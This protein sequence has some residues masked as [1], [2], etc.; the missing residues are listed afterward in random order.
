MKRLSWKYIA[1]LLDGEG[2]FDFQIQV[3]SSSVKRRCPDIQ[4][5]KYPRPR[6]RVTLT[7][8]GKMVLE[9]L[10]ADHGGQF[11]VVNKATLKS[12][13]WTQPYTWTLSGKQLRPFLQNVVEHL[14]IKQQQAL[15]LIW[16][17]DNVKGKHASDVVRE[18]LIAELK[19]M[20]SDPQR[21]S[22]AAAPE[23][24]ALMR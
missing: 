15:F 10:H 11:Y 22:E 24:L 17:I 4:H 8:P 2:C 23:I 3:L 20:K 5:R 21:L 12:Q 16:M 9:S 6:V 7:E 13:E 14:V 19:A 18:R 1:G